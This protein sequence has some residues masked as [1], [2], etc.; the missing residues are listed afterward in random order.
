VGCQCES[1]VSTTIFLPKLSTRQVRI[2]DDI[3]WQSMS[4]NE[5]PG[6]DL[7]PLYE[8]PS[9]PSS[10][11]LG[12]VCEGEDIYHGNCHCKAISYTVKA[13]R[14]ENQEVTRCNCSLCS[15]VRPHLTASITS[16]DQPQNGDY[17][18]YPP[19][20]AVMMN[21]EENLTGYAFVDARSL[22]SFC[23]NC[24]SSICVHVLHE[25]EDLMPLNVRTLVGIDL[26]K[27]KYKDYEG[28]KN[29]PIYANRAH[30]LS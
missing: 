7:P 19:A 24:G 22:R 5:Y 30:T 28:A 17:F 10:E 2:L 11:A 27:L 14:L 15:R 23:K 18:I 16:A 20:S 29:K 26:E 1:H 6:A 25:G 13:K 8:P 21:G 3:D 4:S 9:F 12:R